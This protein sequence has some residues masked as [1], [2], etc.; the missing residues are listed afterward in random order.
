MIFMMGVGLSSCKKEGLPP[1]YFA[2]VAAKEYYDLLI[3]G[4]CSE[5]VAGYNCPNRLPN[6]YQKQLLLNAQM[7]LEQQQ[8]EHKGLS[9]VKV[10]NAKAD[11]SGHVADVF[12]Q[13]SY[14]DST[15]EQ[16]AVP[17]VEVGGK[18]KMR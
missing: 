11:T 14:G 10:L 3:E 7:F 1:S 8:L 4:K 16:I 6:S 18:W 15:K 9:E 2:G 13:M 5:F 12:L 17:M